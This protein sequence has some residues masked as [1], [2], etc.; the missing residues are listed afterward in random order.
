[1]GGNSEDCLDHLR[2]IEK[3]LAPKSIPLNP[4]STKWVDPDIIKRVEEALARKLA[5]KKNK[6]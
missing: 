2:K 6:A 1:M 4:D 3:E 5:E